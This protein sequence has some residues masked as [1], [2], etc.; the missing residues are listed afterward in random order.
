VQ[1]TTSSQQS[2][3]RTY[4]F[5]ISDR[6]DFTIAASLTSTFLVAVN[7]TGVAEGADGR[8]QFTVTSDLQ[9]ATR[10]SGARARRARL[11]ELV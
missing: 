6:S 11:V 1:N 10:M 5:Q 4:E 3:T 8:T 2:G 7:Q 9:P